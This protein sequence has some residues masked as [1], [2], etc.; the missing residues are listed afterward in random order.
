MLFINS[1]F[2]QSHLISH[3]IF[4]KYFFRTFSNLFSVTN[5]GNNLHKFLVQNANKC[6]DSSKA[7]RY[8]ITRTEPVQTGRNPEYEVRL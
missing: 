2:N 7:C 4:V 3:P 1:I 8:N 6:L 5:Y